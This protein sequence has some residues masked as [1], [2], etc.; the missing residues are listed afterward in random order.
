M[1]GRREAIWVGVAGAVS[2]LAGLLAV[3]VWKESLSIPFTYFGDGNFYTMVVKGILDHGWALTNPDLGWPRGQELYDFPTGGDNGAVALIRLLG[4]FTS[5]PGL[6]VNLFFLAGFP[7]VGISAYLVLRRLG[8]SPISSVVAS[9]IFAVLPYHV[10]RNEFHLTLGLYVAIPL[11]VL[12]LARVAEDKQLLTRANPRRSTL[13]VLACVVIGSTGI[14]YYGI[15]A[16]A[17]LA[18]VGPAAALAHRSWRPLATAA[19][20]GAVICAVLAINLSPSI[21]YRLQHGKNEG[22]A[23]RGPQETETF[24]FNLTRLVV[25]PPDH[26]FPPIRHLSQGFQNS[27]ALPAAGENAGYLG[28]V[29][30][31]GFALLMAVMLVRLLGGRGAFVD[32]LAPFGA[33]AALAFLIGTT[34]GLATIFAYVVTPMFHGA[35][36]IS[37]VIAFTSLLAVALVL[38]LGFATL[39]RRGLAGTLAVAVAGAALVGAA[40]YDQALLPYTAGDPARTAAWNGD[41]AFVQ[42]IEAAL[43]AG[44][45]VFQLPIVEFTEYGKAPGKLNA[46]EMVRPY[47]HSQ[48]LRWSYGAMRSRPAD[49]QASLIRADPATVLPA[50]AAVGFQGLYVD[51]NGYG[52]PDTLRR[53]L[54]A[55]A[56]VRPLVS[57]NGRLEFYDLRGYARRLRAQRSPA[58]LAQLRARVLS[59]RAAG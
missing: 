20:V 46:Y 55:L 30:A 45:A 18:L 28:L 53:T 1:G 47:L 42:R 12:L 14:G 15:F 8:A 6:A 49:W 5:Q 57:S 32:R 52:K 21:V 19:S 13:I 9:A 24:A 38:D 58:E 22:I 39:L 26:R 36:R 51:R 37:L 25:G 43:P 10:Y 41:A 4:L 50:V 34:D 29:A 17:L 33:I 2:L 54:V 56:R 11:A 48:R 59:G 27:T 44:A 16:V 3:Q 35:G 23:Q 7:L 31:A 40:L